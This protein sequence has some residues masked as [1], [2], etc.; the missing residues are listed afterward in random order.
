MTPV[1]G[2]LAV[3]G[4]GAGLVL[5]GALLLRA[6][7]ASPG[8]AR[9]LAGAREVRVGD[10][11]DVLPTRRPVRVIGRVRCSDPLVTPDGE[12]LIAFH[13]DVEVRS[14]GAWRT[15]ERIRESRAFDLW[16]HDG[17][18]RL[19]LAEAAEPLI[20]IPQVW[21][22]T[23][24]ELEEPLRSAAMRR[25]AGSD[26]AGAEA[27]A[28]T[29]SISVTDRLLVLARVDREGAGGARL[30]PPPGGFIVSALP[31]DAAMRLLGGR[32]PRLLL[33]GVGLI[34]M[35]VLAAV[36]GLVFAA[37]MVLSG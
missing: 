13:R 32:R 1:L 2:W 6:S 7:G 28:A 36:V 27:R 15:V 26:P 4:A 29:R 18:A 25:L 3:A 24:S 33:T 5:L 37:A 31:L 10:L 9:R 20:A 12:R 22:G 23:A 19:D 17:S 11:G 34:A 30:V 14:G 8:P 35:G 21:R 16:D